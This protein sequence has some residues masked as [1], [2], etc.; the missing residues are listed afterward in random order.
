M[1]SETPVPP[2]HACAVA[3]VAAIV[4]S[5][6]DL[7][8]LYVANAGRAELSL[9]APPPS[10][11][12]VGAAL[13]V[14]AIPV[15]AIGYHGAARLVAARRPRHARV[16]AWTGAAAATLGAA[17]HGGT[18]LLVRDDIATGGPARDPLAAVAGA[19]ALLA[20]WAVATVLVVAASVAFVAATR[21]ET[22][23]TIRLLAWANPVLLTVL[24][25][26]IGS[27][28]LLLHAFLVP[29]APNLAHIVFF[30]ACAGVARDASAIRHKA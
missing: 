19:P 20:M 4:A 3:A 6:G 11:L 22:A 18:A 13:G 2:L 7:L 30:T 1:M 14:A 16:I 9:M 10:T 27:T 15:Y 5:L 25:S 24:L 17:I 28:T 21:W 26:L 12:W 29:A 23:R 8:M